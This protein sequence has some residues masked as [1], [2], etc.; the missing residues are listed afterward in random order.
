MEIQIPESKFTPLTMIN[1]IVFKIF[2]TFHSKRY[3]L[4]DRVW[5]SKCNI[6]KEDD[7]FLLTS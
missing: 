6:S 2:T 7:E 5:P 1:V 3:F 4:M